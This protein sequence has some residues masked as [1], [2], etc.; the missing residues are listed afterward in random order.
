M[1]NIK[2]SAKRA[3]IAQVRT[4]RNAAYKSMMKT[5]I[6]RFDSTLKAED[7]AAAKDELRNATRMIDKV[8]TKGV[9]HKNT[10]NR[11][12]SRLAKALNRV[13]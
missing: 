3:Q 13:S 11:R 9:I 1:A 8:K 12:K 2:S 4:K 7:I 5:A 10:A 6:R